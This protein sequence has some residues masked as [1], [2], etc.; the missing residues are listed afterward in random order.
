MRKALPGLLG[1]AALLGAAGASADTVSGTRSDKLVERA[2]WIAAR[3]DRGHVELT[4]RRTLYNG[5]KRH[6]Q[7]VMWIDTPPGAVATDLRTLSLLDGRPVWYRAELMEAEAAAA[8]YRELTGVGGYYPKDPALL[9]WRHPLLLALQVFPVPPSQPKTVEYT[10]ILPT[11]YHGGRHHVTL[12]RMGTE[13]LFARLAATQA[14]AEDALFIDGKQV[15]AGS[16]A[17]LSK[18][19]TELAIAPRGVPTIGGALASLPIGPG[20]TVAHLRVEAAPRLAEAPRGAYV[21]V[22]VDGSRSFSEQD[23]RSGIAAAQAAIA[24][25]PEARVQV[26]T[27]DRE[28]KVR[29]RGFVPGSQAIAALR[30]LNVEER[31][32]SH[33]DDALARADALL[34]ALPS[35]I[36]KR[37]LAV[38]DLA[39]RSSLTPERVAPMLKSGAVLH[40]AQTSW[41]EPSLLR[42]EDDRWAKVPR[43]TGGLLW[44]AAGSDDARDAAAMAKVFEEWAR[45]MRLHAFAVE[46]RG[47]DPGSLGVPDA[48]A[49]GEGIEDLRFHDR[50]VDEVK[51]RGE[52]WST[53]VSAVIRPDDAEGRLWAALATGAPEISYRLSDAETMALA[54]RGHAVTKVTSL[55][56]IEPGVRPSTEGLEEQGFG[57]GFGR[58]GGSHHCRP[59]QMVVGRAGFDHAAFLREQVEHRLAMC[60][61]AG[62]RARVAIESTTIEIV[63]LP[64][65]SVEGAGHEA[66]ERCLREATWELLLPAEFRDERKTY[67]VTLG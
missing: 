18:D 5:G 44:S 67:A 43:A 58:L 36:T 62:R 16:G 12:P 38:T 59:V 42:R 56:A 45:P 30:T 8:R 26:L 33:L 22:V 64:E 2:H 21:V 3:L 25:L 1:A 47:V 32:G 9:S 23:R 15:P 27:F 57:S 61:G 50:D 49:E 46:A 13:R 39:T 55:L 11:R 51:I 66:I 65:V 37:I 7:A 35:R 24:H 29:L 63:D 31:N 34:A 48:L 40:L 4:V 6:D 20:R 54:L 17:A 41:S 19:E 10:L 53:R 28:V 52:L 60:N 14:H